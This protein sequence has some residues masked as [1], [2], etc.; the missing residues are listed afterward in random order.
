MQQE[1]FPS[2]LKDFIRYNKVAKNSPL[3]TLAPFIDYHSIVHAGGKLEA[4]ETAYDRKHR[5]LLP[6]SD[7]MTT[8]LINKRQIYG[9]S[10]RPTMYVMH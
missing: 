6:Y 2:E 3:T 4:A 9:A 7:N 8:L 5:I 1:H 10:S